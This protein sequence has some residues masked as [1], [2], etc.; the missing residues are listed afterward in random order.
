M[1][2]YIAALLYRHDC[3]IIPGFGGFVANY[4]PAQV[5]PTQHTFT[6]PCKS[7][8]FNRSLKNN[9]GLLAN[10]VSGQEKLSYA[11]ANGRIQEFATHCNT[12][13]NS[14]KKLLLKDIGTLFPDIEKNIQFQPDESINF[15]LESFGLT[16][17]QSP[18]IKRDGIVSRLEKMPKDREVVPA[19]LKKRISIRKIAV[20]TLSAGMLAALVY[21]PLQTDWLKNINYAKLNPFGNKEASAYTERNLASFSFSERDIKA[22]PLNIPDTSTYAH[23]SFL[24][25]D[26]LPLTV[27]MKDQAPAES[28]RVE[29]R[30]EQKVKP[31]GPKL[32]TGEKYSVI[33]GCFAVPENADHFVEQLRT[34]GY[35]AFILQ[36][37]RSMLRHVSYGSYPSYSEALQ[38]LS[39]VKS[40]NKEAWLLVQ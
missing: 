19:E 17:I 30:A 31:A 28:T 16:T 9:D 21:I 25:K 18:A 38:M 4:A 2:H 34:E 11:E 13:L 7:L 33:G 8:V 23:L 6:P 37:N 35:N 24:H 39:K 26:S 20:L 14:G 40:S 36:T 5:H 1:E 12:L 15:Y 29:N 27:R 3:V 32:L 10:F 22:E